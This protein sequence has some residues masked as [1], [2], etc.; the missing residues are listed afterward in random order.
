MQ[1]LSEPTPNLLPLAKPKASFWQ[2]LRLDLRTNWI[3]C[4]MAL[5]ALIY[6]FVYCYMPIGGL[7]I[8]FKDY[9][10]TQS[11]WQAEWVG[12]EHF[13]DFF[14]SFYF[15]RLLTNTLVLSISVLV[16]GFPVPIIFALL[17]NE[18]RNLHFKKL[19]QII[20][21]I[22]HFISIVV[23]CGMILDFTSLDGLINTI[24]QF[25]GG[26]PIAFLSKAEYFR[27]VYVISEIW[28]TFGWNSIRPGVRPDIHRPARPDKPRLPPEIPDTGT[29]QHR[30]EPQAPAGTGQR[31]A[32]NR[33]RFGR[34]RR[35]RYA[36]G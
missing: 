22:P 24:I 31:T 23:I 34:P 17:L 10:I 14:D 11:I 2:R 26:E 27:P 20:T 19:A 28:Q 33:C 9:K 29:R 16:F 15:E 18:M 36:A 13:I 32:C 5:P 25:F 7:L 6:F 30:Q 21:Y 12:F 8:A 35:S 3:I 1:K 4:L